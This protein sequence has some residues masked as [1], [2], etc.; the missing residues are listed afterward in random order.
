MGILLKAEWSYSHKG[1]DKE[2][3]AKARSG[4][5][6]HAAKAL[7]ELKVLYTWSSDH[8]G[9]FIDGTGGSTPGG[10]SEGVRAS[11]QGVS[12]GFLTPTAA[13]AGRV[14]LATAMG[15]PHSSGH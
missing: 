15:T 8:P 9:A 6:I 10:R 5:L 13:G 1:I 14:A 4:M 7:N 2:R 12:S 11:G 3:C